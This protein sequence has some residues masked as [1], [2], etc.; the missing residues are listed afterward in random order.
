MGS[1]FIVRRLTALVP[2]VAVVVVAVVEVATAMTVMG[3]TQA[4]ATPTPFGGVDTSAAVSARPLPTPVPTPADTSTPVAT[5]SLPATAPVSIIDRRI[6]RDPHGIWYVDVHYPALKV[7]T[8]PSAQAIN[9]DIV[10]E[11]ESRLADFEDGPAVIR[12]M[13]GKVNTLTGA[14]RVD[15]LTPE[16]ASY[17][18][19]WEDDTSPAHPATTITTLNYWLLTGQRLD[20]TNVFADLPGALAILSQDARVQLQRQLGAEYNPAIAEPGLAASTANYGG[21]ALTKA[22]LKVTFAEYQ[23]GTYADGL[24]IVVVPWSELA[25]VVRPDGPAARLAA[26]PPSSSASGAAPTPSPTVSAVPG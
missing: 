4:D 23:V 14:Y 18:I 6:Q 13:P 10:A 12:Q 20:L 3:N 25:A 11:V 26:A 21:W 22:G 8:T 9:E 5:A 19:R 24:P 7:G 1:N 16:L 2:V 17:T 15:L